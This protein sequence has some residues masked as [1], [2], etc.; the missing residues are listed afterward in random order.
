MQACCRDRQPVVSYQ[1]VAPALPRKASV[2]YP[3]RKLDD[4]A[5]SFQYYDFCGARQIIGELFYQI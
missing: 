1:A 5:R 3:Y 2:S 4:L